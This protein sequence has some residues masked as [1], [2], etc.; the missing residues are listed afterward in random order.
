MKTE[1]ERCENKQKKKRSECERVLSIG[2]DCGGET[3]IVVK[4]MGTERR[5]R[6]ERELECEQRREFICSKGKAEVLCYQSSTSECQTNG[7]EG[8]SIMNKAS[9]TKINETQK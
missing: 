9:Q 8:H 7:R 6:G 3:G 4:E 5:R 1:G 2:G